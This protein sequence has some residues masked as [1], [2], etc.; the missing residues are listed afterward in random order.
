MAELTSKPDFKATDRN[1]SISSRPAKIDFRLVEAKWQKW[2]AA[3]KI[4]KFDS[5]SKK[6]IYSID[7]PPAYASAGHLHVGHGLH[8]TQFELFARYFRMLGCNV[9]FAPGYDDNGLPTEKYVEEKYKIDKSK[10]SKAEFRKLCLEESKKVEEE[11][12]ERVYKALGHSYDWDLLYTTISSEAQKVAQ[13]SFLDL[14]KKGEA[15]R[16]EEPTLW[17]PYHQTAL[18]QAEIEDEART[19][20]LNYIKFK[21]ENGKHITIA[22]TRPELLPSCV[23]IFVNPND[24]R[25]KNLVGKKAETPLFSLKVPIMADEKVDMEFGT[26]IV[27]VCTF[28]DKTDIEWWKKHKLPLRVCIT[29]DGKLNKSAGKYAGLSFGQAKEKIIEDIKKA[30]LLEKQEPL[31]QTVG[32]CWRCHNPV[33]FL[34][35]KQWFIKTL[36]HKKEIISQARKIK[37]YPDFYRK[38]LE[39]WTN[40]LTWDWCISRQRF[41]GVPIPVWY[42]KKCSEPILPDEKDSPIDPE[43]DNPKKPCKCGGREFVPEQDVFDTWMTSSMTPQIACRWLK[44]PE[45]YK[46]IYPMS[47]RPQSHDIIRTWAFYTIL[48]SYLH[49]KSIPWKNVM[50]GTYVLDSKGRGMHKSLGNAV[51]I[52]DILKKYNVDTFRY[53]VATAGVGEDLMFNEKEFDRGQKILIKLWNT[54]RFVQMHIKDLKKKPQLKVIDKWI[55]SRLSQTI[56]EYHKYFKNYEPSKAR[57]EIEM[58]FLH[59]FCDFYLEMVKWR[60]YGNDK[61]A[62]AARCTLYECLLAIL[63]LWAPFIPHITE[64]I[65]QTMFQKIEKDKSIHI[66]QFPEPVKID[67]KALEIGKL[68]VKIISD[69]RKFKVDKN[70]S[71]GAELESYTLKKEKGIEEIEDEIKGTMRIKKI[72][73]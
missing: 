7:T 16:A 38:R 69:I 15:Y 12:S 10:T 44:N 50:I 73:Y 64:E 51:W 23:G 56:E 66:S 5:K 2:W 55:L 3:N 34:V 41:Y 17:C 46:K 26:G 36:V 72:L 43:K 11:Y 28:G 58:F 14:H 27:M 18:A 68:A 63:K 62:D 37:W 20:K 4:Y 60:L 65:Y 54:A 24:K 53:W 9:Y 29:K 32:V 13:T 22:T 21:L 33:E 1:T 25:Y 47:L 42:C 48:K 70:L 59:E 6:P 57:K 8:Y 35:T 31:D 71:L 39:D 45:L 61:T 67:T 49:F 52:D 40:N 30:G 19:T